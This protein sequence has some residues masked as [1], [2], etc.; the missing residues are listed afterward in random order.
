[1]ETLTELRESGTAD[2]AAAR[3]YCANCVHCKLVP[4]PAPGTGRSYLRV[5][6]DACNWKKKM[7]EEKI[8]K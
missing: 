1:M 4:T 7:G 3:I 6:C 8:Y 5:R 2:R